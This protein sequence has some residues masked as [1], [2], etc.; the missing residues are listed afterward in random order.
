MNSEHNKLVK[1][2]MTKRHFGRNFEIV[3]LYLAYDHIRQCSCLMV[4]F[5]KK[6][7]VVRKARFRGY[8][9]VIMAERAF[10]SPAAK[11]EKVRGLVFGYNNKSSE[12]VVNMAL[13]I[14]LA[15]VDGDYFT[16]SFFHPFFRTDKGIGDFL[17][18]V[19]R[20]RRKNE[21]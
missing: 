11:R 2:V 17:S 12:M 20:I 16:K 18:R 13:V 5:Y 3:I 1:L 6:D 21:Y 19:S 4:E 7:R 10:C 15:N 8:K 9:W 14:E